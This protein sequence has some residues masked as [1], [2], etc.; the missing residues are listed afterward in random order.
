MNTSMKLSTCQAVS[1]CEPMPR[2]RYVYEHVYE[3][4]DLSGSVE[5]RA[6]AT[7]KVGV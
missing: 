3:T 6:N 1:R 4:V 7:A 2:P 5:V